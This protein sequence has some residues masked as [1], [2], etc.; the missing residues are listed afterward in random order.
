MEHGSLTK[1]EQRAA[2]DFEWAKA[3]Y[4][5]WLDALKDEGAPWMTAAALYE[6]LVAP[7]SGRWIHYLE[8]AK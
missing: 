8:V 5:A 6:S 1:Y 7:E 4:I 2:E 3:Q